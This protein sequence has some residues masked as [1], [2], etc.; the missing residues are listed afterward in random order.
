MF[1]PEY[2]RM[3]DDE[4]LQE[5]TAAYEIVAR[6]GGTIETQVVLPT[7]K[8]LLVIAAYPD[9]TASIKANLQIQARGAFTLDS[10]VAYT[11]DDWLPIL[12]AAKDEAVVG[13]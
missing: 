3:T 4:Q 13:V 12:Q 9:A 11:L 8:V 6:N 2:N 10:Q 1:T 7:E 5:Q